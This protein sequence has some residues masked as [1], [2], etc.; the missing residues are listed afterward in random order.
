MN[1]RDRFALLMARPPD[2]VRLEEAALVVAAEDE[3]GVDVARYLAVRDGI[4][5]AIR[6][7]IA[8]GISTSALSCIAHS[9]SNRV[10]ARHVVP[11]RRVHEPEVVQ[12]VRFALL[13][14]ETAACRQIRFVMPPCTLEVALPVRDAAGGSSL[15]CRKTRT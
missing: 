5:D 13:I 11:W 9:R 12:G 14:P 7:Q 2:A 10:P 6:L 3:P 1:P 4:A 15:R 8:A